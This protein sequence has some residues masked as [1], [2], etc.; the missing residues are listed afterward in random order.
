MVSSPFKAA[1]SAAVQ[2][3]GV[4]EVLLKP[5]WGA[6]VFPSVFD[7]YPGFVVTCVF[8]EYCCWSYLQLL[9]GL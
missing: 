5:F 2:L 8:F 9:K 7:Y 1:A 6:A 3:L 4:T